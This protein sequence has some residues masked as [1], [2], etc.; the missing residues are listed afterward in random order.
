MGLAKAAVGVA[1]VKHHRGKKEDKKEAK[2]QEKEQKK[3]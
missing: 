3:T 1:V 2:E